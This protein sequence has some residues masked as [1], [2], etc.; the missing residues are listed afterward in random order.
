MATKLNATAPPR[1]KVKVT[2][3]V[4]SVTS[5][6]ECY[7][8]LSA[9][10]TNYSTRNKVPFGRQIKERDRI[11]VFQKFAEREENFGSIQERSGF[12]SYSL[13]EMKSVKTEPHA[14]SGGGSADTPVRADLPR[15]F[16]T[17]NAEMFPPREVR[18]FARAV[19][20]FTEAQRG[21]DERW[22][23]YPMGMPHTSSYEQA[24]NKPIGDVGALVTMMTSSGPVSVPRSVERFERGALVRRRHDHIDPLEPMSP[25]RLSN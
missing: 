4:S 10:N 24:F 1:P 5:Y 25:T 11:P 14:M 20:V 15:Y 8:D 19:N 18:N 23:Q 7:K 22:V 6:R 12:R 3:K 21:R 2:P 13:K 16:G 9:R 17:M